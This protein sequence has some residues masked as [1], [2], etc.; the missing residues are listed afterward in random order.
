VEGAAVLG[1]ADAAV[2]EPA[3]AEQRESFNEGGETVHDD[4][5]LDCGRAR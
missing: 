5:P 3:D 1:D 2:D 4:A